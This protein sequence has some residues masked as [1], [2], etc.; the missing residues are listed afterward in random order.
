MTFGEKLRRLRTDRKLTQ[1][2]LAEIL[3]VSRTAVSKWESERGFPNIESL[4]AISKFFSVTVDELLSGDELISLAEEEQH[5]KELNIKDMIFGVLDCSMA[6]LFFLPFFAQKEG[7]VI[8]EVSLLALTEIQPYLKTLYFSLATGSIILGFLTLV[9]LNLVDAVWS[10]RK[11]I[12][13]LILTAISV[14]LFV[15]SGQPYA[16]VFTFV[17]M[18]IKVSMFIKRK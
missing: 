16:A 1:D 14:C 9:L 10:W 18:I 13:S 5:R 7:D 8:Q 6:S 4:K 11:I 3:Y 2:E 15:V 12:I 17:F